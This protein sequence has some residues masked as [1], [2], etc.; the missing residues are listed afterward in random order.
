MREI[1]RLILEG[2]LLSKTDLSDEE[3]EKEKTWMKK[4][5]KLL[6]DKKK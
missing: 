1:D 5:S 6:E 4:V 3:V 2:L